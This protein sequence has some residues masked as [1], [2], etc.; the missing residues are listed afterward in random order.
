MTSAPDDTGACQPGSSVDPALSAPQTCSWDG[1]DVLTTTEFV[2]NAGIDG[3]FSNPD[4]AAC[5]TYTWNNGANSCF[6]TVTDPQS[7]LFW[8]GRD[9]RMMSCRSRQDPDFTFSEEFLS[10][11]PNTMTTAD[12]NV[13][14]C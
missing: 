4:P 6:P 12:P 8:L 1:W 2:V 11:V 10:C 5:G 3:T 9:E 7:D 13:L 14:A